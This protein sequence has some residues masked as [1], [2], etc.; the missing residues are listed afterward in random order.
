MF[1]RVVEQRREYLLQHLRVTGH[2][3]C[4][5]LDLHAQRDVLRGRRRL[6][7]DQ[8][9][10]YEPGQVHRGHSATVFVETYANQPEPVDV[11]RFI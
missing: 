11:C 2:R 8:D 1:D 4:E 7:C 9:V 3:L 5:A 6:Q 10:L